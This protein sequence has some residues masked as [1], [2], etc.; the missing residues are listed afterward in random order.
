MVSGRPSLAAEQRIAADPTVLITLKAPESF[1]NALIATAK[2]R[3]MTMSAY[4]REVLARD[5]Q[6]KG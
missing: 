3:G 4:A 2:E 6:G 1:K 5:M